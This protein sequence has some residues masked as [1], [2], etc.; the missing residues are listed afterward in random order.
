M[1]RRENNFSWI[2]AEL[3]RVDDKQAHYFLGCA[4]RNKQHVVEVNNKYYILIINE[5][6]YRG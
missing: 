4:Q 3:C 2:A 5:Y 1:N 6:T